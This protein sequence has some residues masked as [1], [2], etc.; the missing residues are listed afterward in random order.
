[1]AADGEAA[2]MDNVAGASNLVRAPFLHRS[3][4]DGLSSM[5]KPGTLATVGRISSREVGA[6]VESHPADG[7]IFWNLCFLDKL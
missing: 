1:M 7:L 4:V 3:A 5:L 2:R 6:Y